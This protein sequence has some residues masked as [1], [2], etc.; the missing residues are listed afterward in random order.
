MQIELNWKCDMKQNH[1]SHFNIYRD[2]DKS[3]RPELLNFIG[4]TARV[5]F[6]DKPTLNH[7]GWI[8]KTLEPNTAYYYRIVAVDR[9][10]NTGTPS[11]PVKV[12]TLST[13]QKNLPP[14][15]VEGVR[16]ILVSPITEHNFINVLFRTSCESDVTAYEI[17]R[18]TTLDFTPGTG[19]KIG[20]VKSD[21]IIKGSHDYGHIPIDYPIKDFDHAMYADMKVKPDQT[22]YY[23]VCAIDKAG[24][25][26]VFSDESFVKTKKEPGQLE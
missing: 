12:T 26:G 7:G 15:K 13:G 4:Q 14:V 3:C 8:R 16:A 2:T 6:T 11:E 24:Q 23:K 19:T 20:L 9:Y 18:S 1:I 5:S 25:K 21:D 17:H 10:N 22:Y